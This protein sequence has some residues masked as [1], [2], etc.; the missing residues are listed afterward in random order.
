MNELFDSLVDNKG[1]DLSYYT[2]TFYT[3][4]DVMLGP[5]EMQETMFEKQREINPEGTPDGPAS[6]CSMLTNT[7]QRMLEFCPG[8]KKKPKITQEEIAG[9]TMTVPLATIRTKGLLDKSFPGNVFDESGAPTGRVLFTGSGGIKSH[10]WLVV[11]GV[12]YHSVLGT[13]GDAV[14]GSVEEEFSWSKADAFAKGKNGRFIIQVTGEIPVEL[15]TKPKVATNK[16]GFSTAYILTDKPE[17]VLNKEEMAEL[18]VAAA[19]DK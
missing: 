13:K 5:S 14:K 6:Q 11:D 12:A 9:M 3:P 15:K 8:M 4:N 7:M 2:N 16:M 18:G 1:I 17:R 19:V 10:T